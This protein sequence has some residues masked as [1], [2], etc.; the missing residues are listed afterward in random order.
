MTERE[1]STA[2][3]TKSNGPQDLNARPDEDFLNRLPMGDPGVLQPF[4]IAILVTALITGPIVIIRLAAP[5]SAW[6]YLTVAVFV[7]ALQS[8]YTSRWLSHP[9]RRQLNRT[10]YRL[11]ELMVIALA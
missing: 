9:D 2:E 10:T 1:K 5:D 8:V 4:L 7:V 3:A 6:R 11:A